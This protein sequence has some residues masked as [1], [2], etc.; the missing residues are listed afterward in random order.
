MLHRT[1]SNATSVPLDTGSF[2][3]ALCRLLTLEV[4]RIRRTSCRKRH[5]ASRIQHTTIVP[6]DT[7]GRPRRVQQISRSSRLRN[8]MKERLIQRISRSTSKASPGPERASRPAN[9]SQ[10][11]HQKALAAS[12][13]GRP[14]KAIASTLTEANAAA[15]C[16]LSSYKKPAD[17]AAVG[18]TADPPPP[19]FD[20]DLKLNKKRACIFSH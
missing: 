9:Q 12:A 7:G 6:Q 15:A 16:T 3:V 5:H 20:L 4:K 18:F 19:L 8:T 13:P 10:L 11:Q 1:E 14:K 17:A 2:P